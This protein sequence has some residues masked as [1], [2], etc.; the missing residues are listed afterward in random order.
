M[1]QPS[2]RSPGASRPAQQGD[3]VG[4]DPA[5]RPHARPHRVDQ[6]QRTGHEQGADLRHE[7]GHGRAERAG[8]ARVEQVVA[9]QQR[10]RLGQ[11]ERHGQPVAERVAAE[12][13]R[14]V[15]DREPLGSREELDQAPL[16]PELVAASHGLGGF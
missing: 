6:R 2:R 4:V 13:A 11:G 16:A 10:H 7:R 14:G 9:D 12:L 3:V 15:G 1:G 8:P 5:A